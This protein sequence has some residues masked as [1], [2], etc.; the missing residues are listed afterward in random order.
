MTVILSC[1][2]VFP[3]TFVALTVK[4]FVPV[5][6]GVPEINPVSAFRFKPTGREPFAIAQV[7][8]VVPVAVSL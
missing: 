2:V 1:F 7:I 6:I 5:A 8:G 3:A 4:L